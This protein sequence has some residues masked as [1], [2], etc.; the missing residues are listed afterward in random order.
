MN[1]RRMT[2]RRCRTRSTTTT[3][4][5]ANTNAR[6]TP[7]ISPVDELLGVSICP[8]KKNQRK[9]VSF[10][11]LRHAAFSTTE[12]RTLGRQLGRLVHRIQ[13]FYRQ[14]VVV[15]WNQAARSWNGQTAGRNME[16]IHPALFHGHTQRAITA[17]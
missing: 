3:P 9:S 10:P 5:M 1:G 13:Q 8:A 11:F 7:T 6:T 16:V 12:Y 14:G 15:L 4:A 2:P 17:E